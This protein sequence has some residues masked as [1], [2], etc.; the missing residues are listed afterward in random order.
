MRHRSRHTLGTDDQ[1]LGLDLDDPFEIEP[2]S[3]GRRRATIALSALACAAVAYLWSAG[4][5]GSTTPASVPHQP[6]T[7]VTAPAAHHTTNAPRPTPTRIVHP[8]HAVV[9]HTMA[10]VPAATSVAPV[11]RASVTTSAAPHTTSA[12]VSASATPSATATTPTASASP[13]MYVTTIPA[14]TST[15]TPD[16]Y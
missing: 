5:P 8:T 10:P 16:A 6:S 14:A 7:A 2:S 9:L 11:P 3:R 12:S 4:T 13:S 15:A 1:G